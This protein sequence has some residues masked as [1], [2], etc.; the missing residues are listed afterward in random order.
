M[1]LLFKVKSENIEHDGNY[2][3]EFKILILN[4]VLSKK[5]MKAA[6]ASL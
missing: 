5:R 3:A 2:S 1:Q 4:F 6:I